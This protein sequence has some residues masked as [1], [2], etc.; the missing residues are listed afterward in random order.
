MRRASTCSLCCSA[1][2]A[3]RNSSSV[4]MLCSAEHVTEFKPPFGERAGLVEREDS[5]LG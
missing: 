1:V 3:V 4:E 5:N 2:A